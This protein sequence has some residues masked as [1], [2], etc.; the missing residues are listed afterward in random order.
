MKKGM[1]ATGGCAHF[2]GGMKVGLFR[3]TGG[4]LVGYHGDAETGQEATIYRY[5]GAFLEVVWKWLDRFTK[6]LLYQLSYF[7]FCR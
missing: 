4:I 6:P 3:A 5:F 1:T 7:G 2:Q